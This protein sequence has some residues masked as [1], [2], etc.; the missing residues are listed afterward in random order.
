MEDVAIVMKLHEF[1]PVGGRPASG[2]DRRRF[3]RFAKMR[4]DFLDRPWLRDERDQPD[5]AAAVRALERKLLPQPRHEFRPGNPGCVVRAGL[6]LRITTA[7]RTVTVTPMPAGR[8]ISPLADVPDR[9]RRDGPPQLVIRRK[10][11][12]IAM[13]VLPRRR[14]KVRQTIEE[15]GAA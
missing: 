13:P 1:A 5:V 11:P 4:E 8:G 12:V 9:Q 3:E 10:H 7:F 6:L 14:D 15:L 2:R